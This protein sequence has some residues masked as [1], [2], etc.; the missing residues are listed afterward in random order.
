[1]FV[2]GNFHSL[3]ALLQVND[4]TEDHVE[5]AVSLVKELS[6]CSRR[7][8][9][10]VYSSEGL[11]LTAHHVAPI[12]THDWLMGDVKTIF[13]SLLYYTITFLIEGLISC[14]YQ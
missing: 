4:L 3:D 9:K 6:K 1:L 14:V 11:V 2:A 5:A 12:I 10:K 7:R 8:N 13:L